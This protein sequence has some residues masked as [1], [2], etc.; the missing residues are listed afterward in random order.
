M[1]RNTTRRKI[2]PQA[3][4]SRFFE[5]LES[6]Q[7]LTGSFEGR[8]WF[9]ATSDGERRG[10]EEYPVA[11]VQVNL[12]PEF[13]DR[14]VAATS[15]NGDGKYIFDQIASGQ[16]YVVQFV[17][18]DGTRF[19]ARDAAKNSRDSDVDAL[20]LTK[21]FTLQAG[22]VQD[23]VDAGLLLNHP[24]ANVRGRVW[25]DTNVNGIFDSDE[26][27]ISNATV[28]L[29]NDYSEKLLEAYTNANGEYEFPGDMILAGE[30][31]VDFV[32]PRDEM[33]VSP[34]PNQFDPDPWQT[35]LAAENGKTDTIVIAAGSVEDFLS[36]E[37]WS[38][39]FYRPTSIRGEVFHAVS[40]SDPRGPELMNIS[41]TLY[42]VND[43]M[44]TTTVTD[45]RGDFEFNGLRPGE[46]SVAYDLES[47]LDSTAPRQTELISVASG[48]QFDVGDF[49]VYSPLG[50]SSIAGVVWDDLNAD[51]IQDPGEPAIADQTITLLNPK[52]R[53]L[54]DRVTDADGR[55]YF[56]GSDLLPGDYILNFADLNESQQGRPLRV[57]P[58][59]NARIVGLRD[60]DAQPTN[61]NTPLFT[62]LPH[63][64]N[65]P[66]HQLERDAGLFVL[67]NVAGN[68]WDDASQDG[69]RQPS[70]RMVSDL[71]VQLLDD[72]GESIA[73]TFTSD[74]HYIFPNIYPGRYQVAFENATGIHYETNNV[75][76]EGVSQTITIQSGAQHEF[77][78]GIHGIQTDA[79]ITGR[80]WRDT[81]GDGVRGTGEAGMPGIQVDLINKQG[82]QIST[83]TDMDGIY[84]FTDLVPTEYAI[85]TTAPTGTTISPMRQSADRS[86]DSDVNRW[87]GRTPFFPLVDGQ[88]QTSMDVGIYDGPLSTDAVSSIRVSE[89]GFIGHGNAEFTEIKNVGTQ[90]VDL[91][92][93]AFTKG[94]K[95]DFADSVPKSIFPGEHAIVIGDDI[96]L[97]RRFNLDELNVAGNYSGDLNREERMTLVQ[98]DRVITSFRYDDDWFVILDN[99]YLPWTLTVI[100]EHAPVTS[101]DSRDNWRPSSVLAGTP[102]FDDPK[103][104]PDP[105]ALVINEVL[106]RPEDGFN[107]MIEIHNR[108]NEDIDISNW[109]LG[110]SDEE[111]EPLIY[112]TRYRIAPGTVVPANG[113]LVVSRDE[114][115]GNLSDPGVNYPFG[116]S[117]FGEAVHLI[118]ADEFGRMQGYSDSARFAGSQVGVSFGRVETESGVA[119]IAPMLETTFGSANSG[120]PDIGPIVIDQVM[121]SAADAGNDYIRFLN[122]SDEVVSLSDG[123]STWQFQDAI[124]YTFNDDVQIQPGEHALLVASDPNLFRTRMGLPDSVQVFGPYGKQLNDRSDEIRLVRYEDDRPLLVDEVVYSNTTPWPNLGGITDVA[125][126][127]IAADSF[128]NDA[129]NWTAESFDAVNRVT[130]HGLVATRFAKIDDALVFGNSYLGYSIEPASQGDV[131]GDNLFN[132]RD[133][134]LIF[135]AG[136][137]E[138]DADANWTE[139]DW[140]GDGRF[141][142]S[143]LVDVFQN[144]RY[145]AAATT[146]NTLAAAI[147]SYFAA[148]VAVEQTDDITA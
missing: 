50:T 42:D 136:K 82:N 141:N 56:D 55:Y 9:D 68:V 109:Y 33:E 37:I 75:N 16:K 95:F 28:Q 38:S 94:V 108:T 115:F 120:T 22:E 92:E 12:L 40:P 79:R 86:S 84:N 31:V 49:G 64:E 90:P 48:N 87:I 129:F 76:A 140:N 71:E 124:H 34:A 47:H 133:L 20:G 11:D 81:N 119:V 139:G 65:S 113:Y 61:G 93:V 78:T 70:E 128:G 103:V 111:V 18:P 54:H 17:P 102:G 88:H 6:R 19:T 105:G 2:R 100:D 85:S 116:L 36:D 46:Y 59:N 32:A 89:V 135:R 52:F 126:S 35:S 122:S 26:Q 118:A 53:D 121:F 96:S 99:E 138:Q 58:R 44:V 127:R 66:R 5:T 41:V 14:I 106:T 123:T 45:K 29:E 57:S 67:S 142:S 27:P 60:N 132:S 98:G 112:L 104:L 101:W 72:A 73:R 114:H 137:F 131:D 145:V 15:T 7:L 13:G 51:G 80:V 4:R 25:E 77:A 1:R 130:P 43:Q 91:S 148:D 143:D 107:D 10:G 69:V 144:G 23:D 39:G 147:D 146:L 83:T 24:S 21:V 8:V 63:G 125:I 74:G 134:V 97:Q 3:R 30:Y 117:S 110:D 62:L